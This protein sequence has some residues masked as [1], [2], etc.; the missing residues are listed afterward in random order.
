MNTQREVFN[1]LFKEEKTELAT[2][3]IELGLAQ[4]LLKDYKKAVDKFTDAEST[5]DRALEMLKN[6]KKTYNEIEQKSKELGVKVDSGVSK[7][8]SNL[9]S[10]IKSASKR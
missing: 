9:D 5:M 6:A 1:K 4:D 3:K 10:F 7:L 2:Q 8:G